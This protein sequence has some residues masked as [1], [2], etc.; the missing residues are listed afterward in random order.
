M[1]VP[2]NRFA[3]STNQLGT[4]LLI[5]M[6]IEGPTELG[7]GEYSYSRD[8]FFLNLSS[9]TFEKIKLTG[10]TPAYLAYHSCCI[11][12]DQRLIIFGGLDGSLGSVVDTLYIY[13]LAG[14]AYLTKKTLFSIELD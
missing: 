11:T 4:N 6:G 14:Y 10:E 5:Q 8:P 9:L 2:V 3:H 1:Q 7:L 13:E 12:R